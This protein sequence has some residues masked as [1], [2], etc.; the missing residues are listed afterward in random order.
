MIIKT[1]LS[2]IVQYGNWRNFCTI[3]GYDSETMNRFDILNHPDDLFILTK[4][5]FEEIFGKGF[6]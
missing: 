3:T 2:T 1:N 6:I 4:G 5:E